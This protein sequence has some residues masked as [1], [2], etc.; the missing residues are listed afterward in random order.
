[1]LITLAFK[2]QLSDYHRALRSHYAKQLNLKLD[3]AV[4]VILGSIGIVRLGYLPNFDWLG[5]IFL[6]LSISFSLILIAIFTLVPVLVF[7][8]E[9][10]FK[11]Q[12]FLSFSSA[13]IHFRTIHLDS[14][15]QWDLYTH[16][17][18]NARSYMLYY[19]PRSF[20]LIPKRIF[21]SP[22]Q[23]R[24]FEQLLP[25]WLIKTSTQLN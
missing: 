19:G 12:Y 6:L 21:E 25:K 17:F 24:N 4:I 1:M 11:D 8:F 10:K 16:V 22:K 20:T 15:I 7:R 18:I 5:L 9:P 2:Y 13:G 23:Q 14:K 3:I